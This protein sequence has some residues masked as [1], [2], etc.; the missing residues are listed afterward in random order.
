[1]AAA[2]LLLL[3][4][5]HKKTAFSDLMLTLLYL[6]RVIL[7]FLTVKNLKIS[8]AVLLYYIM[9]KAQSPNVNN[10]LDTSQN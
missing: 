7:N 5:C 9:A 2:C 6:S 1:M 4:M 10:G 3:Q 8:I